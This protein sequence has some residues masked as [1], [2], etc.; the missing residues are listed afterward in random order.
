LIGRGLKQKHEGLRASLR[1]RFFSGDASTRTDEALLKLLISYAI[2]QR[3]VQPLALFGS[4]DAVV[5][6][7]AWTL[8]QV[9]KNVL[10][11]A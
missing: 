2:P 4:M 1:E 7:D 10:K 8:H 5:V 11:A 9:Y 3:E 6:V